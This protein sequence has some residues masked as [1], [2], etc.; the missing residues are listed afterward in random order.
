MSD[1]SVSV[2]SVETERTRRIILAALFAALT[3][4]G[5]MIIKIPTPTQG[6]IH[7]GD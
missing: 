5:T 3:A 2:K 6:Y 1:Q 4:V 7:P